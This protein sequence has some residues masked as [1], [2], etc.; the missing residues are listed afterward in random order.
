MLGFH[1]RGRWDLIVDVED[2]L[3]ASERGNAARNQVREWAR[4]SGPR[5]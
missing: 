3:L 4:R 5:L 2:C 1:A